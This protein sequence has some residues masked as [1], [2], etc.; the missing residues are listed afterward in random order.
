M[1]P[2]GMA[3][4]DS[5]GT[6]G[7]IYKEEYYTVLHTKYENSGSFGFR[8]CIPIVRLRIN[9]SGYLG[10]YYQNRYNMSFPFYIKSLGTNDPHFLTQS[11]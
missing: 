3:C 4:M 7:R 8:D 11:K 1:K 6:V 2:Q 10:K 9:G 5:R